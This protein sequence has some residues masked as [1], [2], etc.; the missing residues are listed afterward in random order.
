MGVAKF[1]FFERDKAAPRNL[2]IKSLSYKVI[3][4]TNINMFKVAGF[5]GVFISIIFDQQT[6]NTLF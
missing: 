4:L 1:S 2:Q 6:K 5:G 3:Y